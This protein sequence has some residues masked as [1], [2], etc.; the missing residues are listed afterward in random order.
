MTSHNSY[1]ENGAI[2]RDSTGDL[3][4]PIPV[5]VIGGADLTDSVRGDL[6]RLAPEFQ[7]LSSLDRKRRGNQSLRTPSRLVLADHND[8]HFLASHI[9]SVE[10][11][12][13][14]FTVQHNLEAL[15]PV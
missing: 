7:W 13:E 10:D 2:T 8:W 5:A 4:T 12:D 15:S 11:G 6:G 1:S 9:Q 14:D 3:T